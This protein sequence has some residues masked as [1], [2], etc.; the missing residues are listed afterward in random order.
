[1]KA[2]ILIYKGMRTKL[3]T[4]DIDRQ[5]TT[6]TASI[7]TADLWLIQLGFHFSSVGHHSEDEQFGSEILILGVLEAVLSYKLMAVRA[8]LSPKGV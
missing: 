8:V 7:E 3:N 6:C 4:A 1:M 5:D 2:A